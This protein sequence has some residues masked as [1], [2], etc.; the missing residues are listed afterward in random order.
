[1]PLPISLVLVGDILTGRGVAPILKSPQNTIWRFQNIV[2]GADLA[3][4]NLEEAPRTKRTGRKPFYNFADLGAL[5]EVGFDGFSLANNHSL[6]AGE[7]GAR[8]TQNE[9]ARL[10]LKGAGLSLGGS[11]PVAMW[12]IGGRR[13]AV[14]AA[15]KWGPFQNKDARL[16]R[17]EPS[18]LERQIRE[19]CAQNIFVIVSLH[20]GTEGVSGL[21]QA[22]RQLARA[23]IDAG[24]IAVWGHHPHVA[25][26]V[27]TF[28]GRPI[29]G[30]T[31]NFLWDTM[32]TPQSGSLVR[33]SIEGNTPQTAKISWKSW[34]IDPQVRRLNAPPT[35]RGETRVAALA[36]RFDA[37]SSRISWVEWTNAHGHPVLRALE[38]VEGGWRV[39]ATGLPRNVSRI[40]VGDVNGDGRD[41]LVVELRQRSKLDAA[42]K[43]R[44]HIYDLNAKGFQPLWR[45]SLLSRPF[46]EWCLVGRSDDISRDLVALERGL[47]GKWVTVYRWNGFG[48]R[49]VWQREFD[50]QLRDLRSGCDARGTWISFESVS[51]KGI[52]PLRARRQ[53]GENWR[54]ED[55]KPDSDA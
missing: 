41:E 25:G 30:S 11:N 53:N 34:T 49:I 55:V 15:T 9:L 54:V 51:Q 48:L 12:N 31:G 40:E 20:W 1:M 7:V 32:T 52:R 44:L 17:L 46:F 29:W 45:G 5:R 22:Q 33:L 38:Q 35:R 37:D 18:P 39:R 14:V 2:A 42:E 4:G 28:K 47:N 24:A 10:G 50:G 3:L 36:G 13:V 8:Q 26:R 27:E 21:T 43:P 23:L 6:D 19:L 16:T